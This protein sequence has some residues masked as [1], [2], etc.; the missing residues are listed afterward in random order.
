MSYKFLRPQRIVMR[1]TGGYCCE[2][3]NSA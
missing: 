2:A 3:C 1:G